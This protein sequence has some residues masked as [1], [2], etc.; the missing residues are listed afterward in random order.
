M[1]FQ[2]KKKILNNAEVM[3]RAG[4]GKR[5]ENRKYL[6]LNKPNIKLS[7]E[8]KK[9]LKILQT[10]K[11]IFLTGKAGTGKTTF[12]KYFRATTKKNIVV[13]AP[14]GVAAVNIQG[15][16]I[17]S[18]FKFHL[19]ITE[20]D[21]K[22]VYKNKEIYENI[23]VLIIDEISMVRADLFDC[24]E[25]FLRINGPE[26]GNPFGGIQIVIVGDLYQLPPI[27]QEGEDMIFKIVY[28]SPY[29][30]D[31]NCFKL[32]KFSMIELQQ[33]Y[34]QSDEE[35]IKLLDSI[36]TYQLDDNHLLKINQRVLSPDSSYDDLGVILVTNNYIAEKINYEKLISLSGNEKK[37]KGLIDGQFK[38]ND[39]PTFQ[40]L[41]L[42]EGAQVMLLNNDAKRRWINGDI[43]KVIKME[44]DYVRVMFDDGSFD[45]INKYKWEKVEFTLENDGKIKSEIIGSFFQFPMKLAWA[46]TIHKGQGN[47]YEK[48]VIDFGNG[49]FAPGQAYV[50]LSRC[51]SFEGLHLKRPLEYNHI[52]IDERVEIFMQEFPR[53][54]L[55]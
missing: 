50:A 35:F 5:R 30:F 23:D 44:D 46:I 29:F 2:N 15:Q 4:I 41:S 3:A 55:S 7:E 14:T 42:K 27:V 31:A 38:S 43:V 28:R 6:S 39:L 25:K 16:T 36:R 13:L 40:N 8:G 20:K 37:Y 9:L 17:H 47:T 24:V 26:P 19:G 48:A 54:E 34:R 10:G 51:R 49:T 53:L 12:L 1:I 32:G 18:F 22:K 33:V 52:L 45:D 11:N 21:V